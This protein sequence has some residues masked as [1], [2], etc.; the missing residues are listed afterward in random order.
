MNQGILII[1]GVAIAIN[2]GKIDKAA[3]ANVY[4]TNHF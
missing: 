4:F 1:L 3:Q 2:S